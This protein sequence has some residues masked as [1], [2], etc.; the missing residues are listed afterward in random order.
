MVQVKS[1][2]KLTSVGTRLLKPG[3]GGYIVR[4]NEF[5]TYINLLQPEHDNY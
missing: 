4:L 3:Q 2:D 5:S 1:L